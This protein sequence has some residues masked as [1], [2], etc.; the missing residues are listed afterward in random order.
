M[1]LPYEEL[2]VPYSPLWTSIDGLI[3]KPACLEASSYGGAVSPTLLPQILAAEKIYTP[4][5]SRTYVGY[6][7]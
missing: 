5:I 6:I 3:G 1:L 7:P 2:I 4:A